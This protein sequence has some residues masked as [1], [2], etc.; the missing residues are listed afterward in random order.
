MDL[1]LEGGP[2]TIDW[3]EARENGEHDGTSPS[4][5]HV[6]VS[7]PVRAHRRASAALVSFF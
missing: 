4:R 6:P 2:Q 5:L 1:C 7:W 3:M